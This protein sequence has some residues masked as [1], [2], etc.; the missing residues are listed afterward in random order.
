MI[1]ILPTELVLTGHSSL[2]YDENIPGSGRSLKGKSLRHNQPNPFLEKDKPVKISP[3]N[4]DIIAQGDYGDQIS[5]LGFK[6]V[7][8][9]NVVPIGVPLMNKQLRETLKD[10]VIV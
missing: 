2:P 1:P 4:L 9:G 3:R 8:K 7:I 6:D 5:T 10:R